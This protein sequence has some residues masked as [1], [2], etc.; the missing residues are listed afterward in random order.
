[1]RQVVGQRAHALG[2]V[3]RHVLQ[4]LRG[5]IGVLPEQREPTVLFALSGLFNDRVRSAMSRRPATVLPQNQVSICRA[6]G[7]S[8][9][10]CKA[11]P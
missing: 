2:Q 4:Q 7:G 3:K 9:S 10:D 6:E 1:M 5:H 8:P 11:S